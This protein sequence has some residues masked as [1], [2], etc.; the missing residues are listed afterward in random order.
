MWKARFAIIL[1][2]AMTGSLVSVAPVEAQAIQVL[3][4][5]TQ[6]FFDQPPVVV[7][8]RV[9]VPLRGVFERL[10]AFVQ[11][12]PV[13]NSVLAGRGS[14][15]VQ[16][17][18]GSTQAFVNGRA[19][20]L[21]VPAMIVRGRTL[22]PLRFVSE[23]MGARVDWDPSSR[24]VMIFSA[25]AAR[26]PRPPVPPPVVQ[27]PP[28]QSVIE[29]TVFRV[30]PA[31]RR[32]YVRRGDQIHTVIITSDT[33]I[34]R[35]DAATGRG[36]TVSLAEVREGD[37]VTV[38]LDARGQA[39]LVRVQVREVS[40]RIEAV[41]GRTIVLSGGRVFT[42]ADGARIVVGGREA[43]AAELRV[44]MEVTLRLNPQT[45]QIVEV[46][47][48]RAQPPAAEVRITSFTHDVTRP[49]QA[50]ETIEVELRGTPGGVARFDIFGIAQDVAMEEVS[51]GR[52]RGT[53]RV[54]AGDNV[55]SATVFGRLRA[56][57][58]DAVPV[59]ADRQITIDT[60]D[61]VIRDRFPEPDT[62]I[63]NTRPNILVTF[64]DRGGSGINPDGSALI[65]NGRNVTAQAT[66]TDTVI[67]YAPP[68]AL[69]Q[70]TITVQVRLRDRARNETTSRWTFRIGTVAGGL[71]RSVTVHP[72]TPLLPGQ[73]VTVT[74]VGQPGGRATFS[75]GDVARDIRMIETQPG[76][77]VGRLT[78]R[79][80]HAVANARVFV[81]LT[82]GGQTSRVAATSRLTVIGSQVPAPRITRPSAGTRVGTPIVIRG[83]AL[84]GAT[85]VVR[86]DYQG[87]LL[88]F[89]VRGSYGEVSTA[90][91]PG[92]NWEVSITPSPRIPDARLTI[93]AVAIDPAG[94]RST[95]SQVQV[96][97]D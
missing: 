21:D 30:D 62:V 28:S 46:A 71:I 72:T 78:L 5:S 22:V 12:N 92:G 20:L 66:V 15:Q 50:G 59:A 97:Q 54:R 49:L 1:A 55:L 84:P 6:V 77:Y 17:T 7:G 61:P 73:V 68:Q 2:L 24:T 83:T 23:A 8:G 69:P 85:V 36:G 90:A 63:N 57:D 93:T 35:V 18:I 10:G 80:E 74:A 34:T 53:Y 51:S 3:V 11:W 4:D 89:P 47:T 16:L 14:T 19:V 39:I 91:G 81:E 31:E 82:R 25:P 45:N 26:P 58:Q 32:L 88:F 48:E 96:T 41:A 95:A 94:R 79:P 70:G 52:Y 13:N 38:T 56:R 44:G 9:L 60:R 65:V 29:G 43:T 64:D 33:A 67:A 75:I 37:Q 86:V 27:P 76:L 87:V 40:G 42:L